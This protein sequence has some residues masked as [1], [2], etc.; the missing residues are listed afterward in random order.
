MNTEPK[1]APDV[2][3][4]RVAMMIW[5]TAQL[6]AKVGFSPSY[7]DVEDVEESRTRPA[8]PGHRRDALPE[9]HFFPGGTF[10]DLGISTSG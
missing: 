7:A 6:P 8:W 3:C 1:A 10:I 5:S 4:A 2:L 9:S